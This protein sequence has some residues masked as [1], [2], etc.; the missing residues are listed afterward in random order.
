MTEIWKD[1]IRKALQDKG[2]SM[3]EASL[4]AGKGETFVRD[5]LERGR[6][7]SIDN[8]LAIAKIVGQPAGYLL[9][10]AAPVDQ[11]E[12]R[13][14]TVGAHVQ[15][16]VWTETWEWPESDRYDVY[17]PD[18]P[19][20]RTF[21]LYAAEARG[22]SMNKRYPE[23]TVLVFTDVHETME[24]PIPGKRYVV[25]R[26]KPS[27]EAE[28]TVKLLHLDDDGKY[29]LIPESDDPRFQAPISIEDG[30]GDS[31]TVAI[32]GRVCFAVSRE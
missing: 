11:T 18:V 8:F 22:T 21:Q 4:R 9:G 1:R 14:V 28:H 5:L 12:L 20:Y 32:I 24:D 2:L 31:D 6:A 29:W 25:E 27:G 10:E 26:R 13:R 7:P 16:G 3:K 19:E 23:R 15:A 30:T 17:V